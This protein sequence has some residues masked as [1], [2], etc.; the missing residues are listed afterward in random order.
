MFFYVSNLNCI[1]SS[2]TYKVW[3]RR[4]EKKASELILAGIKYHSKENYDK[5]IE[6]FEKALNLDPKEKN[7]WT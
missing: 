5:A 1:F 7:A 4:G 3:K 6:C 2:R